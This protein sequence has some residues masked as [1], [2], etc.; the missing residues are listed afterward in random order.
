MNLADG[1]YT[2]KDGIIYSIKLPIGMKP[3][4]S[5]NIMTGEIH[6]TTNADRIRMMTDE[7]LMEFIEDPNVRPW[8]RCGECKWESC[9]ECCFEW[10]K[11]E[12]ET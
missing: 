5:I 4:K 7:E 2:V 3:S 1:T 8:Y 12:V 11:Q 9:K 6:Y 10:L